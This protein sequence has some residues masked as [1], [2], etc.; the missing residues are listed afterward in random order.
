M[1]GLT[2]PGPLVNHHRKETI[3]HEEFCFHNYFIF[4]S[5]FIQFGYRVLCSTLEKEI[6]TMT[7][8][9]LFLACFYC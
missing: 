4:L 8:Y 5:F 3:K 2:Q 6:G 9:I 7:R 1:Y